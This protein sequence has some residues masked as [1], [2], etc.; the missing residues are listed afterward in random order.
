MHVH[1]GVS[2]DE[3]QFVHKAKPDTSGMEQ[4]DVI[5]CAVM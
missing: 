1:T 4:C 3:T 5:L 2:R